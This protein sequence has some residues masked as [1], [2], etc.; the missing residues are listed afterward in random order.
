MMSLSRLA[1]RARQDGREAGVATRSDSA[2]I[3]LRCAL[4]GGLT[5]AG[6]SSAL[7]QRDCPD[8][9]VRTDPV[10]CESIWEGIGLPVSNNDEAAGAFTYVCHDKFLVRHNNETKTPD[11]VIERLTAELVSGDNSRPDEAFKPDSCVAPARSAVDN[12]YRLSLYAR[13]HQAASADFSVNE[14]WMRDTFVFSNAVPQ[15]GAGFNSSIWSE[16]EDKVRNLARE[17]GEIYVITGPVYQD[18]HGGD[19]VVPE[20]QN[21][22]GREIRLPALER[23]EICGGTKSGG[24]TAN[25]DD[26]VAIPAGLFKI[27]I[28]PGIDRVNAYLLPNIDHPSRKE[29]GTSTEEYLAT[30][31]VSVLNLEDRT[32]YKFLPNLSRHDRR[33]QLESCP[34]TMF[35]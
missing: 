31:R 23:K 13:G 20:E 19:I 22:C 8:P 30:W 27:I 16:F 21:P 2:L 15:E 33:A 14:Q 5:T 7:A 10:S 17:R 18:P 34:A 28:D 29:R 12:D 26:G 32:G 6:V 11:W 25:C 3:V 35:R 1:I 9:E 4:I 24:P